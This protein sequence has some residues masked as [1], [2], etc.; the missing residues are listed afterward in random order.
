[1]EAGDQQLVHSPFVP[2]GY[3][4]PCAPLVW[5][6]VKAPDIRFSSSHFRKQHPRH[7]KADAHIK[8]I[9]ENTN[10][11]SSE[12]METIIS[13]VN[14]V[15]QRS[16]DYVQKL[17]SDSSKV[18]INHGNSENTQQHGATIGQGK[19]DESPEMIHNLITSIIQ[20]S[21]YRVYEKDLLN[22]LSMK[23][24]NSES[25]CEINP[26]DYNYYDLEKLYPNESSY[27]INDE[28]ILS[29]KPL[30]IPNIQWPTI[31]E[32]TPKLGLEK[33]EKYV[34]CWEIS[35]KW[36]YCV[37]ILPIVELKNETLHKYRVKFS[38][39]SRRSPIPKST[40]S[41]YFTLR[42]SRIKP[43]VNRLVYICN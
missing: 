35:D 42:I 5:N 26:T 13:I 20:S 23:P 16:I 32:F 7:E 22:K 31:E 38:L 24:E 10:E 1:M 17:N 12:Y 21:L 34:K 18:D 37:D 11:N 25:P 41:V 6:P 4:S 28:I 8:P 27:E 36:L 15:I 40:V 3:W 39:P 14:S 19:S 43:K 9:V 2:A 30:P 33:I 29:D